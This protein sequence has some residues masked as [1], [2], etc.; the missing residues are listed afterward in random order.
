MRRRSLLAACIASALALALGCAQADADVFGSISLV[1]ASPTE[2]ADYA[3][4]PAI[5]GNGRYV[6]FDGSIGG[7]TGVWR[8]E[9][10]YEN[11]VISHEG[12]VE[13]VAGGDADAAVDQQGR[14]VRQ[15]H[16]QR[17]QRTPQHHRR[18]ARPRARTRRREPVVESPNVYVRN[19]DVAP[20]EAGA[21]EIVSAVNGSTEPLTLR[22]RRARQRHGRR[23]APR[24][25]K[26]KNMDRSRRVARRS[27]KADAR[28]RSSRR[29]RRI[30]T[31]PA[32]PPLEVAV[33]NLEHH[34]TELVSVEYDP[35]TG[36]PAIDERQACQSPCPRRAI[37]AGRSAPSSAKARPPEFAPDRTVQGRSR[38]SGRR[39]APTARRSRGSGQE[40]GRAG[41]DA[42][43][44]N[45]SRP[46]M[47]SRCGGGSQTGRRRRRGA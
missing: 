26:L 42:P 27:P 44:R 4:D 24:G 36:K 8:R 3:H 17:R 21:F 12:N 1:S 6:V 7:V 31:A 34:T 16:D 19:M 40:I 47:P 38:G 11:G 46:T 45:A 5:S 10:R 30:W 23:T 9:L 37:C 29:P 2:Q 15:L 33:R 14:A 22:I 25:R 28:W 32:T 35:A 39:S 18:P 43:G 13:E 20:S 41:G